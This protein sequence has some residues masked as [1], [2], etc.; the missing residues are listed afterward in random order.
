MVAI[1]TRYFVKGNSSTP[2]CDLGNWLNTFS[3]SGTSRGCSSVDGSASDGTSSFE[4]ERNILI[5]AQTNKRRKDC[6]SSYPH[7]IR[8]Y[9]RILHRLEKCAL[10]CHYAA[11]SGNFLPGNYRYSQRSF[12]RFR[13]RSLGPRILHWLISYRYGINSI[14]IYSNNC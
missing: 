7:V 13:G 10:L 12:H 5:R 3:M 9:K 8:T 1:F 11:N 4:T 14:F 6:A 2:R